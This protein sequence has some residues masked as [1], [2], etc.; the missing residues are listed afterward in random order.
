MQK[1]LCTHKIAWSVLFVAILAINPANAQVV[2]KNQIV[3]LDNFSGGLNTKNSPLSL[4]SKEGDIVENFRFDTELKSLTKRDKIT[5]A[6]TNSDNEASTGLFRL[7]LNDGTKLTINTHGDAIDSCSDS[8][9]TCTKILS[10]TTG[11]HKWEWLT[12]HNLA[13]GTDGYNQPVKYDGTSASATYLG[14]LLA[15]DAG[16]GTGASGTYTYKVSCYTTSYEYSLNVASNS[17]TV[18]GN[19]INLSMIPICPDTIL[20]KTIIGRKIYR[21]EGG[22]YK[23][24]SNGTIADNSTTTLTDSDADGALGASYSTTYLRP[25]PKGKRILVHKNRLWIGNNPTYHSRLYFSD[26]GSN[27]YFGDIADV[28]GAYGGYFDIRPDDGD[29]ITFLKNLLGKLT[30]SKNNT[31]QKMDTDGDTPSTD[32]AVTDPFS[33][34]GCQ[35]PYSAVNT[36]I[37]IIY[38]GNNGIYSFNGQYSQLISDQVTPEIKDISPTN[39]ANVWAAY[40]K[41]SYYMTYTSTRTGSSVNNRV[42][43]YDLLSKSFAT[44]LLSINVFSVFNSGTDIEALYSGSSSD[45]KIYAHNETIKEIVHKNHSD[46][47]GTFNDMRYIP[48]TAGGLANSPILEL[49]RTATIDS[50]VGTIDSVT[51]TIDRADTDGT[52][53]SQVL[54]LNAQTFD[55]VYWNEIIPATGGNVT[56]ALRSGASIDSISG[57]YPVEYTNSAGSDISAATADTVAQYRIS[58]STD[59]SIYTPTLILQNNYIV[60]LTYNTVGSSSETT[61][62]VKWRSGWLDFMPGYKKTLKKI[63]AYYE[64]GTGVTGTINIKFENFDGDNDTFAIDYQQYQSYYSEYFT[65]GSLLGEVFRITIDETS[66]NAVKIKKLVVLFDIEPLY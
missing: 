1:F 15:T 52:Y 35:A 25:V 44:D 6:Y 27:D 7:Y 46:F 17:I 59:N 29:E 58:M 33:F 14:S 53:I 19:D 4:S 41:N 8:T 21:I 43:I 50:V 45:G 5:T 54:T 56:F 42:M 60:K 20:G 47:T 65:G 31:I 22:T 11:D 3:T 30:V 32:W 16:S 66:L 62:P 34:I 40:F 63:Y 9:G 13:I 55:K 18:T 24:L 51:G 26:D 10:L 48:I 12:W 64:V 28:S 39:F 38:L 49:A 2:A 36:P 37:G 23:L 57:W 61:I